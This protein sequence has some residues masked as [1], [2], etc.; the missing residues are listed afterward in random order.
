VRGRGGQRALRTSA[1]ILEDRDRRRDISEQAGDEPDRGPRG[2]RRRG[3]RRR[4]AEVK[5]RPRR[6]NT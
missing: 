1:E 6:N 5:T 4:A 3:R 2:A